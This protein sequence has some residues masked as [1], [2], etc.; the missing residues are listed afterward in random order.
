MVLISRRLTAPPMA[1]HSPFLVLAPSSLSEA[2]RQGDPQEFS[3]PQ[4]SLKSR[5]PARCP[6]GRRRGVRSLPSEGSALVWLD[7]R[8]RGSYAEPRGKSRVWVN[9]SKSLHGRVRPPPPRRGARRCAGQPAG[10]VPV[11]PTWDPV[12]MGVTGGGSSAMQG[13]L[14]TADTLTSPRAPGTTPQELESSR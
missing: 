8:E 12:S 11:V 2:C 3:R 9:S 13:N 14:T 6:L 7:S 5:P 10:M 4:Q 1:E